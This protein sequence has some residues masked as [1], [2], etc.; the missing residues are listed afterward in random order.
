MLLFCFSNYAYISLSR[1]L[2]RVFPQGTG[3][4]V[5]HVGFAGPTGAIM[6]AGLG[7]STCLITDGRFSGASRGFLIGTSACSVSVP[8]PP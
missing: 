5:N 7:D 6:G 4:D 3:N 1:C 2:V 8:S